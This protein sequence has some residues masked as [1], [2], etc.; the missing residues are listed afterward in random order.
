MKNHPRFVVLA[1]ALVLPAAALAGAAQDGILA[2][3]AAAARAADPAFAG[4]SAEPQLVAL[5]G[6]ARPEAFFAML[7]AAG[8]APGR[9]IALSDHHDFDAQPV[10]LSPQ[11]CVLCTEK[12]AVKLWRR[13]PQAWAVP[14][15][16]EI[17]PAFWHAF[18]RLLE[19]RLSSRD[20]SQTA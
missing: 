18:D 6:I 14:L 5:A 11:E 12:D 4:F 17:E 9:R 7:E 1:V 16:L 3:T 19:A 20:G 8:L 13:A 10:A 2:E 15:S